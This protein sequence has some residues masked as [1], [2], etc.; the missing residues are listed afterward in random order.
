MTGWLAKAAR[1][2]VAWSALAGVLGLTLAAG[3]AAADDWRRDGWPRH[4]HRHYDRDWDGPRHHHRHYD[5]H[6]DRG[7]DVVVVRPG[8]G[9]YYAPPPPVYYPPPP[10]YYAPPPPPVY[11][12][13]PTLGLNFV[14]PIR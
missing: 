3:P 1:R 7:R 4:H 14:L 9:Y 5:R 12:G 10:V 8:P 6:Y 11:Y 2:G 13:P